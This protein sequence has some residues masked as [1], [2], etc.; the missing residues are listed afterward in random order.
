M[1][2]CMLKGSRKHVAMD[3]RNRAETKHSA[4]KKVLDRETHLHNCV[5]ESAVEPS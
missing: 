1:H 2:R 5:D 4:G 3:G